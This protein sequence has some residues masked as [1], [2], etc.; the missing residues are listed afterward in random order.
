MAKVAILFLSRK[1]ERLFYIKSR[2][3]TWPHTR[4]AHAAPHVPA[5]AHNTTRR[6]NAGNPH[7]SQGAKNH[8]RR[9]KNYVLCRK[10]YIRHNSNYIRPFFTVSKPLKSKTLHSPSTN[11]TNLCVSDACIFTAKCGGTQPR[12]VFF[13]SNS[14]I[15]PPK[16]FP[17]FAFSRHHLSWRKKNYLWILQAILQLCAYYSLM[18]EGDFHYVRNQTSIYFFLLFKPLLLQK[19]LKSLFALPNKRINIHCIKSGFIQN[20]RA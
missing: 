9:R 5:F 2:Q 6:T 7:K 15:L 10:N 18:Q 11:K 1:F 14:A 8:I 3:K 19:R 4:T 13:R 20:F 16:R 12:P 17:H